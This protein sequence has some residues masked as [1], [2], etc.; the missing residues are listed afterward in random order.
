MAA[1]LKV[2]Q[3]ESVDGS[4]NITL[5]QSVTMASG[6]TLPAGNLTG[7]LPAIS[8]ANLTGV[9][10]G[11]VL[12][13][14]T[15]SNN[16]H[17]SQ[18][19]NTEYT[20]LTTSIT[21][22]ATTSK[23]L[24]MVTLGGISHSSTLDGGY[25]ITRDISGGATTNLEVGTGGSRNVTFL[26]TH[27]TGGAEGTSASCQLLDSPNTTSTIEYKIFGHVNSGSF[28]INKRGQDTTSAAAS[29]MVLMEIG[30]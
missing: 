14:V 15:T 4:S 2:D 12:Q 5:N 26:G 11:K 21:P 3:I 22:S 9:S 20:Q 30:A 23:I 27:N 24:V 17:I 28:I 10:G 16:T 29:R 19:N 7:A 18:T 8:G 1:K 25:I 13:A 6:K